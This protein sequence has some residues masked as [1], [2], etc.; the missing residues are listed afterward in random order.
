MAHSALN[1]K[2]SRGS[3]QRIDGFDQRDDDNY[4]KHTLAHYQGEDI[5]AL[6][7]SDVTITKSAPA[8]RVYGAELE[9]QEGQQ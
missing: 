4:L 2:E 1:R 8:K 6:S 9:Q 5:P 7:Y 3:H